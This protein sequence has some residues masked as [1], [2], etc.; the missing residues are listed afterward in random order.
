MQELKIITLTHYLMKGMKVAPWEETFENLVAFCRKMAQKFAP[1]GFGLKLRQVELDDFC[2]V[3]MAAS[4]MVSISCDALGVA[5]TPIENLLFIEPSFTDCADCVTPDGFTFPVRTF[6]TLSGQ[7]SQ[8]LPEEFFMEAVL[9]VIFRGQ[10]CDCSCEN[11]ASG[12]ENEKL[13]RD[14]GQHA[15]CH[16]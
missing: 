9:K 11:C 5:E 7:T 15:H 13:A 4:N 3:N 10:N 6:T 1:L 2:E 12:C 8:S 16:H 14:L